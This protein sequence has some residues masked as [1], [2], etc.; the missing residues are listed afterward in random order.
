VH[1]GERVRPD[2]FLPMST[3]I[4]S[5]ASFLYDRLEEIDAISAGE[6][7]GFT[8]GRHHN[9]TNAALEQA[10]AALEGGGC[11]T[12]FASGMAA[13]L[14][15]LMTAGAGQGAR[16]VA[17][18]DL[19]GVTINALVDIVAR[20]GAEIHFVDL[21]KPSAAD[22]VWSLQPRILLLE[23]LTNPLLRIPDLPRWVEQARAHG[24]RVIVDNTFATPVLARPLESGA[25]FVVHSATKYL[26]GHGDLV[27][28][29]VLC[30]DEFAPE[31]RHFA[32][33]AGAILGPFEAWLTLRGLKTLPLRFLRQSEN[34]MRIAQWLENHARIERVYYPALPSH[35]DH[36][37]LPKL[38]AG[39]LAGGVVTFVIRD[40]GRTDVFRF[41][42]ALELFLK[43]TSMGDL[44]SLVLYPAISS[45]R[46]LSPKHRERLGITD[47]L[48]R[49][50][51]GIEDAADLEADLDQA[52]A[53]L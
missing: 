47:N 8:Y 27:G 2:G 21:F 6:R 43:A 7:P 19:Y 49:L 50:S 20:W 12:S 3:P 14:L 41:V 24:T 5:S 23:T 18:E 30:R 48:V 29:I 36:D 35:P 37:R 10:V 39:G 42:N 51:I 40:A 52:L 9:P 13:L 26:G 45:H 28:G 31:M 25:D 38:F 33:L 46:D 22:E 17:S 53:K 44:Q 32:R 15:A 4:Y 11:G 1:A 16:I 34:A